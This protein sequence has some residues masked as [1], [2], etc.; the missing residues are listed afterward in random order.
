[1]PG[2]HYVNWLLPD[3]KGQPVERVR[4]IRDDIALRVASLVRDLDAEALLARGS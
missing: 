4:E 1:V 2:K 3:P